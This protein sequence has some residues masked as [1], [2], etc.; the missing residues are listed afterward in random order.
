MR[1]PTELR[2]EVYSYLYSVQYPRIVSDPIKTFP[3]IS[4][5]PMYTVDSSIL[6][7]SRKINNEVTDLIC[8]LSDC[9]PPT[10]LAGS[11]HL[12]RRLGRIHGALSR[13]RC[14]DINWLEQQ[15]IDGDVDGQ[16]IPKPVVDT[17]SQDLCKQICSMVAHKSSRPEI[18]TKESLKTEHVRDFMEATAARLRRSDTLDIVMPIQRSWKL[19]ILYSRLQSL[20]KIGEI[21]GSSSYDQSA[22]RIRLKI[23]LSSEAD[24]QWFRTSVDK[25]RIRQFERIGV[26]WEIASGDEKQLFL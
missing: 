6:R 10:I 26:I 18:I 23:L 16:R 19:P 8:R 12:L 13:T 25:E 21:F 11:T 14:A 7:V 2:L 22:V 17:A 15:N 3:N 4:Q 24:S 20:S 9:H 1:L 5:W